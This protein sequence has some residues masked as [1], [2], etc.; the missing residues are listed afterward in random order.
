MHGCRMMWIIRSHKQ[1]FPECHCYTHFLLR[2]PCPREALAARG[3]RQQ[4][5]SASG[6]QFVISAGN[7]FL[8]Q[9]LPGAVSV[10]RQTYFQQKKKYHFAWCQFNSM[11]CSRDLQALPPTHSRKRA[12][13]RRGTVCT[14]QT[15]RCGSP[16]H[17]MNLLAAVRLLR[18]RR[19][20]LP[21]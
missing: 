7:N 20:A 14:V 10:S 1:V 21:E 3:S 19:S 15:C 13:H 18:R 12:S 16:Q 2:L 17:R 6:A 5:I 11:R 4:V 9:G 8:P